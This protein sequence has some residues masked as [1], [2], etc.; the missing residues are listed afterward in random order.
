[1]LVR[2]AGRDENYLETEV[3][4][5]TRKKARHH[6]LLSARGQAWLLV[7]GR[8]LHSEVD[9]GQQHGRAVRVD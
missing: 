2:Q 8:H 7:E 3:L 1:V 5:Q 4:M 6:F 9:L